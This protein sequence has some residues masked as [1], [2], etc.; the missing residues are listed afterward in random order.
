MCLS[1]LRKKVC[2][3]C[4]S[5]AAGYGWGQSPQWLYVTVPKNN[6]TTETSNTGS[7][8]IPSSDSSSAAGQ[9]F[10]ILILYVWVYKSGLASN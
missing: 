4:Y 1:M 5:L 3:Y 9:G 10:N 2:Y 6:Q 8:I 7:Y